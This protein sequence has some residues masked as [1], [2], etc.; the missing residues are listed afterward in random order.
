MLSTVSIQC[1]NLTICIL[2][3]KSHSKF[4]DPSYAADIINHAF[5]GLRVEET[6]SPS[7]APS[8]KRELS[9]TG[10]SFTEL[11]NLSLHSCNS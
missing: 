11:E 3:S 6:L 9:N 5:K 2:I 8:L 7:V 1:F 4:T 10:T